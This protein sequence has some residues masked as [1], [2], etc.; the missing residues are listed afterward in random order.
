MLIALALLLAAQAVPALPPTEGEELVVVAR[1]GK[2][3][4]QLAGRMLSD[5]ELATQ[6]GG[7]VGK[8]LRVVAPRGVGDLCLAKIAMR[9]G[10]R[11]VNLV[12]FVD[13]P[14]PP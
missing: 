6:T 9:L 8:P 7:W 14:P 10:D 3:R 13:A 1:R 5:R 11:G 12:E 4:L 2:C